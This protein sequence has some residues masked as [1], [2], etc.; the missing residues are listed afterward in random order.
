MHKKNI[1][2]NAQIDRVSRN[3]AI[4]KYHL[5]L[6]PNSLNTNAT[7]KPQNSICINCNMTGMTTL[8]PNNEVQPR[9]NYKTNG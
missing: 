8:T 7:C 6:P 1:F 3:M 4:K 2:R 5:D 9:F